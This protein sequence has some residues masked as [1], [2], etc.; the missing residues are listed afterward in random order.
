[1][2]PLGAALHTALA[3]EWP[4]VVPTQVCRGY[5]FVPITM[6]ERNEV[7]GDHTLWF[8]FDTGASSSFVD[9]DSIERFSGKRVKTGQKANMRNASIIRIV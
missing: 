5:F 4:I 1:M 6:A 3:V 9:P 8:L 7:P 2:L